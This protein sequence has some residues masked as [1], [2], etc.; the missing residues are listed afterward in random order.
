MFERLLQELRSHKKEI[1]NLVLQNQA[2]DFAEY[3]Y[4]TGKVKGLQDAIDICIE[5]FKGT[6]NE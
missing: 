4:L 5:M 2:A 1:E 6:N 3:R